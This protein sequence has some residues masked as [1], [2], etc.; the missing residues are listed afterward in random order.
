MSSGENAQQINALIIRT[1]EA[2]LPI[3][4]MNQ[5]PLAKGMIEE[6]S[7]GIG[8]ISGE[9]VVKRAKELALIAGC[10]VTKEDS[11]QAL[12]ELTGGDGVDARQALFESFSED[13]RWDPV[14][15]STGHRAEESASED[16]DEDGQGESAQLFEEGVSEAA[17]DQMLQA[18]RAA[19]EED[20]QATERS[21]DFSPPDPP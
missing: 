13:E 2:S 4:P 3:N 9:M 19:K 16:E 5:N 7:T 6:N 14:P 18:A 20:M 11:A 12:R 8:E 17:H 15:G 10:P 21:A 1:N